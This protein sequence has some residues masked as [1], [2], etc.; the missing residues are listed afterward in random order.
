[1]SARLTPEI[2]AEMVRL[3]VTEGWNL[4]EVAEAYG[5][6]RERAR[7]ILKEDAGLSSLTRERQAATAGVRRF[8]AAVAY[9]ARREL[10]AQHGSYSRYCYGCRCVACT[11]A[12]T[13]THASLVG[14]TPS[15]H[16]TASAYTNYGCRCAACT[17]A[18][19]LQNRSSRHL[20]I[21][22][23]KA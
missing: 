15:R 3:H 10:H 1:M 22:R 21:A 5:C 6:S 2:R 14:R 9:V 7:Q 11:V 23:G 13:R 12:N 18:G 8:M 19:S 17:D 4:Q 20:R 16:G